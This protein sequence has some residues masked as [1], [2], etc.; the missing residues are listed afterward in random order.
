MTTTSTQ[1]FNPAA[2]ALTMVAFGRIGIRRTEITVQ[3]LEDAAA[4]ANLVQVTVSNHQP[5]LWRSEIYDITLT[6]GTAE[7]DLPS[8][9]VATQDV[10]ITTTPSGAGASSATDRVLG[11]ITTT[12][13]DAQPN[14][15]IQAAPSAYMVQKLT[16]TPT[17]T[18]RHTP[19][20]SVTYV[21]HVRVLTRPYDVSL[22][23]GYTLDMPYTYLDVFVAG[24]AH[25]LA[26][27]YAR[28]LEAARRV[29]YM[30]ALEAAQRT[31]TQDNTVMTIS[32]GTSGYWR[33]R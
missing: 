29:D 12:Q 2:S 27:I 22:R 19:D 28:G 18:F 31:D 33:G 4:E 11:A 32:V 14:K 15:T 9:L 17:I 23:N 10:Y 1:A 20:G 3:H 26:R 13:Y 8:S 30:E 21:A 16:P 7:Y 5:L 6:Q 25:R 24:L